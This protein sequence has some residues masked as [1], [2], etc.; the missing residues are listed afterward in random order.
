MQASVPAG[1]ARCTLEAAP[2]KPAVSLPQQPSMR[3]TSM[4]L[5]LAAACCQLRYHLAPSPS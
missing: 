5:H 1:C 4:P 3:P 2:G